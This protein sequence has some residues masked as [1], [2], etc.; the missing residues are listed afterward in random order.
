MIKFM[1]ADKKS[2]YVDYDKLK[3]RYESSF[4]I[5]LISIEQTS[6]GL[7]IKFGIQYWKD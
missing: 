2:M 6:K 7:M 3:S 1:D 5:Q 4:K